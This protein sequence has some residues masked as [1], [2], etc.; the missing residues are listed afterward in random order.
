MRKG[1]IDILKGK[2]LVSGDAPKNW[3]FL[4]FS[5]FLAVLMISS[6]HRAD[7]KVAQIASLTEEVR[8]LR[9]EFVVKRQELQQLRLEST[10]RRQIADDGL[11]PTDKPPQKIIVK[12]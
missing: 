1:F 8:A 5:A 4:L 3:L 2:F 10:L 9:S 6:S 12:N 11:L 7:K